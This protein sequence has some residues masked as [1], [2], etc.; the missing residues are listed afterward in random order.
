MYI[1]VWS[2]R[3]RWHVLLTWPHSIQSYKYTDQELRV[4]NHHLW[5]RN[6][7]QYDKPS[8][9]CSREPITTTRIMGHNIGPASAVPAIWNSQRAAIT[10]LNQ[11]LSGYAWLK[12][13]TFQNHNWKSSTT[14]Q[15]FGSSV[16][17]G[18]E[19]VKPVTT[20]AEKK[21][22]TDESRWH[23]K[24]FVYAADADALPDGDLIHISFALYPRC[25][26]YNIWTTRFPATSSIRFVSA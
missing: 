2:L 6:H 12:T 3:G 9:K 13:P 5:Q 22:S 16:T 21:K 20:T 7:S 25:N 24:A 14:H 4:F 17:T 11:T 19:F 23:Q 15:I 8:T 10:S 26:Y 1:K 18:A